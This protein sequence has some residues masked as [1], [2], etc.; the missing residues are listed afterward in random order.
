MDARARFSAA[1]DDGDPRAAAAALRELV[2]AGLDDDTVLDLLAL[3][4][5]TD[6]RARPELAAL[7]GV[8]VVARSA[9][10]PDDLFWMA[11]DRWRESSDFGP[12]RACDAMSAVLAR[13]P[14]EVRA[15]EV[16]LEGSLRDD[17]YLHRGLD[18]ESIAAKAP[19]RDAATLLAAAAYIR[20][21]ADGSPDRAR[22]LLERARSLDPDVDLDAVRT[23]CLRAMRLPAG[24]SSEETDEALPPLDTV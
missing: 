16:Y 22:V 8:V 6:P 4:D 15:L 17:A 7:I 21:A 9:R 10:I 19:P 20:R 5:T 13:S 12:Q 3:A 1:K 14:G 11:V 18:L 2:P 24:M 23:M